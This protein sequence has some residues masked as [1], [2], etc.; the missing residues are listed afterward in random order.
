MRIN[1]EN[2][3]IFTIFCNF[4][5]VIL[6]LLHTVCYVKGAED[7]AVLFAHIEY[8]DKRAQGKKWAMCGI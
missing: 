4:C 8:P 2:Y 1:I 7:E 5:N 6:P 3:S